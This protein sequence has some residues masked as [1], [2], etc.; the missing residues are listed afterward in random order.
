MS[1]PSCYCGH[2]LDEHAADP[3]YPRGSLRCTVEG[4]DCI[5]FEEN[6]DAEEEDE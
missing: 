1:E 6:E 4:C 5:A 2:V 3:K